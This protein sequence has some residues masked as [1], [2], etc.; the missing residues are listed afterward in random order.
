M[1]HRKLTLGDYIRRRNGLPAGARGSL[2][3]MLERSLGASTFAGFWRH[4]NPIFG[5]FLG[6]YVFVPLRAAVP[7][8]LALIATFTVC[9]AL[10]DVITMLVRRGPAFLF[11]PWFFFLAVGVLLGRLTGMDLSAKPWGVRAAVQLGYVGGCLG[12]SLAVR[13]VVE[14]AVGTFHA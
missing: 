6:R 13:R 9:G 3:N 14:W 4:W 11:T 2:Q 10:H 7:T 1:A 8:W 12:L 5:Y